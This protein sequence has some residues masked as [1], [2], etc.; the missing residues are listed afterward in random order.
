MPEEMAI[1]M[2]AVGKGALTD[3][4]VDILE[5]H[6]IESAYLDLGGNIYV[7]GTKEDGSAW[8]IGIQLPYG[9]TGDY[10]VLWKWQI[11]L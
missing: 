5:Q 1:D 7:H 11:L 8:R 6:E 2:G 10:A 9:G 3:I 4:C